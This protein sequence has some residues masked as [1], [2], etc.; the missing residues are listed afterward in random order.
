MRKTKSRI[1]RFLLLILIDANK[2]SLE[3]NVDIFQFFYE[4]PFS[5]I[6]VLN[7]DLPGWAL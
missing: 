5:G 3:K 1:E 4:K 7:D 2:V 6:I